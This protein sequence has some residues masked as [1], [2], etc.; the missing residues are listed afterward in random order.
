MRA[1]L[2][3]RCPVCKTRDVR[4]V[5]SVA[6]AFKLTGSFILVWLFADPLRLRWRCSRDGTEFLASGTY[7]ETEE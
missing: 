4:P 3:P 1:Y 6:N 2:P 5:R 7:D